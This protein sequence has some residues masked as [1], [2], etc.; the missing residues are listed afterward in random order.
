MATITKRNN[1]YRIKVSCGYDCDGKQ[2]VQSMTWTPDEGMTERQI[3]KELNRQAVLFEEACMKGLITSAVK[4][5]K[6]TEQWDKE[7]AKPRYKKVTYDKT[8][9]VLKRLNAEIGHMRIDKITTRHVQNLIGKFAK[10]DEKNG[11]KPMSPKTIKNY[12]SCMSSVLDYAVRMG[13]IADNPCRRANLPSVK[14][15]EKDCYTLEEAQAFIDALLADAPQVYQCY[16]LLAIYGGFRRAELCGL[17]WDN[18][19]FENQVVSVRKTLNYISGQELQLDTPKTAKSERSLKL[20]AEIFEHLSMLKEFYRS[21]SE[22]L[23]DAW[24]ENDFVFKTA[25][26]APLSPQSPLSWLKKFCKREGLRYVTVHSFRHL[27]A[28]LLISNGVDVKT[29]QACLGH[30]QA[31]T[32]MNIYAH[33]FMEAQARA[34]ETVANSFSFTKD[35]DQA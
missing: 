10:G 33:S 18:I 7:Y 16:F 17:T 11:Y 31:S 24:Q 34:S 15:T 26:G 21:E 27:N 28:S 13:L 30:A 29:V 20:P 14:H 32:T 2:V 19:D 4:F 6:F 1:S 9:H 12:I 8:G 3:K 35:K 22:R 23:C 5:E 25:N